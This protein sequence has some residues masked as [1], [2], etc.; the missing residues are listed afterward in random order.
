[1]YLRASTQEQDA[2]RAKQ[3]L[4]AFADT[5]DLK[6]V[7]SYVENE[8]GAVLHRPQMFKMLDDATKGDIILIEQVDRLSRLD[9]ENWAQLRQLIDAKQLHI[10]SLDLPTTWQAAQIKNPDDFTNR[11][12][13]AINAMLLDM[14][15]AMARKDYADRR[16]RQAEGI[17]KA[18]DAGK[19]L[20]R[21]E[22]KKKNKAVQDMLKAGLSYRVISELVGGASHT[23]IAKQARLMKEA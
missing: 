8:S 20:G 14:T 16:R 7:A 13:A 10:V 6:I 15:A 17:A 21:P 4:E 11:M 1:L 3:S 12:L 5:H 18:K 23:T 19:Y 22:N 9:S 2:K